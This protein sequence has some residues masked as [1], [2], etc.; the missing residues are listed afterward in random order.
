MSKQRTTLL[1][2]YLLS[3]K[4]LVMPGVYDALSAKICEAAGYRAVQCSGYG[5]AAS[6]LGVPDIGLLSMEDMLRQSRNIAQAVSIPVM[7]DGDNGF[8]NEV[9]TYFTVQ[10]FEQAG[11]AGINLED[12]VFP[13]R[14]G[15]MDGK[16]VIP[17]E[18]MVLKI[19][20]AVRARA[21]GDFIINARTDAVAVL[22]VDEAVRRGNLYLKAG[23]DLI[24]VEAPQ[25]KADVER[26]VKSI[27]GPVSINMCDGGKTPYIP[28][29][30]LESWGVARV[31]VPV[32]TLFAAARSMETAMRILRE[33]GVPPSKNH[34]DTVFTFAEFTDLMGLSFYRN[35]GGES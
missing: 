32:A 27:D 30:E 12:Q 14:C 7:A 6:V 2:E 15:H 1:K 31:S 24:F 10:R 19:K 33:E 23:A 4:I 21:D 20:A 17:A 8:G 25:K 9:N 29:E 13:K 5:I 34:P 11:C 16:Q 18:E 22:G 28:L 3:D 26:V 35:L